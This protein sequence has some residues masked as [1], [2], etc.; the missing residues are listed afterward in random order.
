MPCP[1]CIAA[2]GECMRYGIVFLLMGDNFTR[3]ARRVDTEI[4]GI[5]DISDRVGKWDGLPYQ[6]RKSLRFADDKMGRSA[7][8]LNAVSPI[9]ALLAEQCRSVQKAI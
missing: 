1:M 8:I 3:F 9:R 2:R 4:T 7:R 5:F 6:Q